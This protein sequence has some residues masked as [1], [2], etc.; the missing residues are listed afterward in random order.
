MKRL[1]WTNMIL[2][3]WLMISPFALLT[4]YRGV[5]RATWEDFLFGFL[6]AS[7]SFCRLVS[8]SSE[9]IMLSDWVITTTGVVTLINPLLYNYYGITLATW[10]N[11]L[12]G[13]IVLLIAMVQ[14]WKDSDT[15]S[16]DAHHHHRAH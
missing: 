15:G 3:I 6:I 14:D 7:F 11:L 12:I 16:W 2:G 13:G 8:H 4:L 10:N 5:F 9:E 1:L